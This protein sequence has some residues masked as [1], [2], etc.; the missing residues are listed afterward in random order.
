MKSARK[1]EFGDFETPRALADEVCQLV[2]CLGET[3]D[4]ILEPTAGEGSFLCAAAN[5]FPK[6]ALRGYDI[7]PDYVQQATRALT[8]AGAASR[9]RVM[10]GDFFDCDWES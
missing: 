5:T 6:A 9:S 4:V 7:N 8:M 10:C 3:P 1:I 2:R